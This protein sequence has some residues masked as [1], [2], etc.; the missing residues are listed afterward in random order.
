MAPT[1]ASK[2]RNDE[3]SEH[4][5]NKVHFSNVRKGGQSPKGGTLTVNNESKFSSVS[6]KK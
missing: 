3:I 5:A 6:T 1:A 2:A 4:Q